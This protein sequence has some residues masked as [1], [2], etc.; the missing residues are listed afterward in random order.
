MAIN[1]HEIKSTIIKNHKVNS[2]IS[3]RQ[4]FSEFFYGMSEFVHIK[5]QNIIKINNLIE[6]IKVY[7]NVKPSNNSITF[8]NS[9]IKPITLFVLKQEENVIKFTDSAKAR[10]LAVIRPNEPTKITFKNEPIDVYAY[11]FIRL[12]TMTGSI[13]DYANKT[14]EETGRKTIE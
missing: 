11:Y 1:F 13:N 12:N 4:S 6:K 10:L 7:F 14:I 3:D 2:T 5:I 8:S 9:V